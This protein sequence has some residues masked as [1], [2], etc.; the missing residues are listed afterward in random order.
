MTYLVNYCENAKVIS[1]MHTAFMFGRYSFHEEKHRAS[2]GTRSHFWSLIAVL[3]CSAML[4]IENGIVLSKYCIFN[5]SLTFSILQMFRY[6]D[7]QAILTY[8]VLII[9]EFNRSL[10]EWF[11][12]K[13]L[14]SQITL[15]QEKWCGDSEEFL[16]FFI[17]FLGFHK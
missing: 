3:W 15:S 9:Q 11:K 6:Y 17:L 12:D 8:R 16:F 7:F 1:Q 14:C 5:C 2:K 4:G 10:L 13:Q